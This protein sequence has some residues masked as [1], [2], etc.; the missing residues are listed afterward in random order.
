VKALTPLQAAFY[1]VVTD[2]PL[3][4]GAAPES[5]ADADTELWFIGVWSYGRIWLSRDCPRDPE[6]SLLGTVALPSTLAAAVAIGATYMELDWERCDAEMEAFLEQCSGTALQN[7]LFEVHESIDHTD[8][9][10]LYIGD[11]TLTNFGKFNNLQE[12]NGADLPACF[13]R[14]VRHMSREDWTREE[15]IFV[16]CFYWLRMAGCRGEEFGGRQ[17]NPALPPNRSKPRQ[18]CLPAASR[19]VRRMC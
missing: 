9:V 15:K 12:R 16:F 1:D 4:A 7:V 19:P 2:M 10:L 5:H 3:R 14:R 13:Y 11:S 8:P 17:L 6:C 18:D